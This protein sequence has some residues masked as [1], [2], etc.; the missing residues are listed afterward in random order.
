MAIIKNIKNKL[1]FYKNK[2][3][4]TLKK[5]LKTEDSQAILNFFGYVAIYGVCL[6]TFFLLFGYPFTLISWM[7]FGLGIWVV[8]NKVIPIIRR[9]WFR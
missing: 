2:L 5:L 7:S 3:V 6:N 1:V 9:L 4:D 8:E